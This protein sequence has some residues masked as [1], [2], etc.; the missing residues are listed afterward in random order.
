MF[1]NRPPKIAVIGAGSSSFSSLLGDLV[2][3]RDLDGARVAL[4][5][6]DAE[7]VDLAERLGRRMSREWG[8][9]TQVSAYDD[10][11]E[12]L[13]DADFVVLLVGVGG[14]KAWKQDEAIPA[15]HGFHGHS[16]DTTGA[17]GLFRGL[18]VIPSILD[19]CRDVEHVAPRALVINYSNPVTA[20]CRAIRKASSANAV[21]L[22]TAGFPPTQVARFLDIPRDRVDVISAGLNH[23]VW[24]LKV[25]IDGEEKTQYFYDAVRKREAKSFYASSV[26]ILDLFGVWPMP[27]AG[28]VAEFFPW[29]F[30]PEKDGRDDG[31]Y[32]MREDRIDWASRLKRERE[33]L[34]RIHARANGL[35][36]LGGPSEESPA[37]AVRMMASIWHNRPA[38]FYADVPNGGTV[39]NLPIESIV[40][41][42]VIAD[43]SGVRA[44]EVGPLPPQVAGFMQARWAY[45]EILADAAIQKSKAL[46]LR[47]LVAD[48]N[49]TS[50]SRARACVD[51]MFRAQR[52]F[53]AGYK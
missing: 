39:P 45:N 14:V 3:C 12:A 44:V 31:R 24:A 20:V 37:D 11:C 47:C 32:P 7:A 43:A 29:F 38:R 23:C 35:E 33:R 25:F 9:G 26:E 46:A 17:G 48:T 15:R 6:I 50:I 30:G 36:P 18:R 34:R 27:G 4:V 2:S 42:P 19:V 13:K 10:R 16:C 28:H 8:R 1:R 49:T 53:L 5:D 41:V 52:E 21:G 40:E 22:C 51:A